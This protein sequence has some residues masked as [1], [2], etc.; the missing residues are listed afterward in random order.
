MKNFAERLK[1][2]MEEIASK[3]KE[4]LVDEVSQIELTDEE[5]TTDA[6]MVKIGM[7][8]ADSKEDWDKMP[9]D[10]QYKCMSNLAHLAS[11]YFVMYDVELEL[12]KRGDK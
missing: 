12:K 10:V 2:E 5:K 8:Y 6:I 1:K 4:E 9:V 7:E 3:K 11:K